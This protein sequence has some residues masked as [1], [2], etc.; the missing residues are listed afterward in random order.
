MN[1]QDIERGVHRLAREIADRARASGA[2][3][4][5]AIVG[6]RRGGERKRR[7]NDNHDDDHKH[8]RPA[9][10]PGGERRRVFTRISTIHMVPPR[11][12]SDSNG[13]P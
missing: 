3:K 8:R 9:V 5:L 1:A 13:I 7:G 6:I 11:L 12:I 2:E 10:H 4:D